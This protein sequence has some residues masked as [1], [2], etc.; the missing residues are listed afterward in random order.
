MNPRRP[1]PTGPKPVSFDQTRTPPPTTCQILLIA[2]GKIVRLLVKLKNLGLSEKMLHG[3]CA[4]ILEA[5][6]ANL[7]YQGP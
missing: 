2:K 1:T 7:L 4:I 6:A 3:G 5:L